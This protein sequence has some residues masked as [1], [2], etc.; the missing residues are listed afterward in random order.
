[1]SKCCKQT[2]CRKPQERYC[3]EWLEC[4]EVN[5]GDTFSEALVKINDVICELGKEGEY[6]FEDNQN[7]VNGGFIVFK[8]VNGEKQQIYSWCQECCGSE[9]EIVFNQLQNQLTFESNTGFPSSN[10]PPFIPTGISKYT[11]MDTTIPNA[12]TYVVSADF[13]MEYGGGQATQ[14]S[15]I[16][17]LYE[18]RINGVA[19]PYSTRFV[20]VHTGTPATHINTFTVESITSVNQNSTLELWLNSNTDN[21]ESALLISSCTMKAIKI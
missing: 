6:E 17:V 10:Q 15:G 4:I 12:G 2:G 8:I 14:G 5:K 9:S 11:L 20:K 21:V 16:K 13:T 7:C 19:I 3:G 18:L 1:M